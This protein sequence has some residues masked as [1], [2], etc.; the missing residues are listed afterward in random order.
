MPL[1]LSRRRRHCRCVLAFAGDA[2]RRVW[3]A[4][5]VVFALLAA[6][7]PARAQS[8]GLLT[9]WDGNDLRPLLQNI[10]AAI[11]NQGTSEEDGTPWYEVRA[12]GGF[13]F[14]IDGTVCQ[15]QTHRCSGARIVGYYD[16]PQDQSPAAAIERLDYAVVSL[17]QAS[18]NRLRILRYLIFD[19]G[20][21]PANFQENISVY[22]EVAEAIGQRLADGN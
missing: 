20:V 18:N 8:P 10:G 9:D 22:I 12:A 5:F 7:A 11:V 16:L 6:V 19:H 17:G 14:Y 21:T 3:F 2:M 15:D 13:R 1:A 4:I